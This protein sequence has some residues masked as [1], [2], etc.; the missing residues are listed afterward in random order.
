[1]IRAVKKRKRLARLW[2]IIL[3]ILFLSMLNIICKSLLFDLPQLLDCSQLCSYSS[4]AINDTVQFDSSHAIRHFPN[5]VCPQNFR[6]LADWVYGWPNQFDERLE[7]TTGNEKSIAPCL[8][9]GSIIYVCIWVIGE[10][11]DKV[12]PH[13]TNNFVLITGE[14]DLSSPNNIEHLERPDSKIIHWFGQNGQYDASRS[15]KFTHIPIG[16]FVKLV[17]SYQNFSSRRKAFGC[18]QSKKQNERS[19]LLICFL[20][21]TSNFLLN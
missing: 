20:R 3:C 18:E 6:N 11:F 15:K 13:L 4:I 7:K 8:P 14:G 10:F 2:R 19:I 17:S 21:K 9:P 5:F 12:Y 16:K 1:M